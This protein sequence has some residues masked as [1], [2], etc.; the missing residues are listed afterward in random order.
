MFKLAANLSM[1]FNEVGFLD[2]FAAAHKAGFDAVE[3]LFPY[4]YEKKE[5]AARL[6]GNGLKQVLFNLSPGDWD[7]GDRGLAAVPGREDEFKRSVDQGLQYALALKCPRVHVM[8]GIVPAGVTME[9]C[10]AVEVENL[11][12]ATKA[13][14]SAGIM[15]VLE[16]LN[17]TDFPGYFLTGVP[18]AKK[19]I[20]A[21]G[22]A[23]L[24][25]QFDIYHQQMAHGA[26]AATLK[27][28]YGL[29]EHV[30]I[31]GSPGRNE[32]DEAQEIN[33]KYLF[34]VLDELGYGGWVGCEY[35]PRAGTIPGLAWTRAWGI[36]PRG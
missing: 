33:T 5:L 29:V 35:R 21:V 4:A 1:L 8:S 6:D 14:A 13:A 32:P 34:G 17:H 22:A 11:R 9:R 28:H 31:A 36:A 16:P 10:E 23:N 12:F 27:A 19:L 18:Q 26:I 20:E 3:Y 15:L 30:Q 25:L 2:R 24:R 7:K